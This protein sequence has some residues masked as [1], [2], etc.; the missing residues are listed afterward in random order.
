MNALH[1]NDNVN[2]NDTMAQPETHDAL[3]RFQDDFVRSLWAQPDEPPT[4]SFALARQPGF[5]VYRNTVMKGCIDALQANFPTVEKLV[6]EAWFRA[7]AALHVR[8]QPPDEVCLLRYGRHFPAFLR[9]FAPA[10]PWPYLAGVAK[11][12]RFWIEAHASGDAD[13]LPPSAL[14]GLPPAQLGELVLAPHPAARWA[15]YD[16][17]PIYSLWRHNREDSGTDPDQALTWCGEG[18]LITRPAG[19][20]QSTSLDAAGCAFLEACSAGHPLAHAAQ[21]ALACD[22]HVD[23]AALMASLLEAGACTTAQPLNPDL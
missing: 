19:K 13:P 2:V 8:A 20:V 16:E 12:D 14:T 10:A 6:G 18:V 9:N 1:D 21:A 22:P 4:S 23:L 15:W 17:L 5:A 11:L 3:A 7:V